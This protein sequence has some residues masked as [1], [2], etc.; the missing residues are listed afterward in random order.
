MH[1][2]R[3]CILF[4][5]IALLVV[6]SVHAELRSPIYCDTPHIPGISSNGERPFTVADSI[7][8]SHIVNYTASD[9]AMSISTPMES[10]DLR[11][12]LLVTERGVVSTNKTESTIWAFDRKQAVDYASN[13]SS[14]HPK[15][16][17]VATL[18]ATANTPVISE[19][20]WLPDSKRIAFLGKND[21]PYQQLFIASIDT[22]ELMAITK[23]SVYVSAYDISG[24][25]VAYSSLLTAPGVATP[26]ADVVDVTG[27]T[28][29]SFLYPGQPSI[30]NLEW[31][32][33]GEFAEELHVER[34]GQELPV[35]FA[36]K[37]KPLRLFPPTWSLAPPLSLSPDGKFLI[38]VSPANEIPEVWSLYKP[39]AG[40]KSRR[41][42][43]DAN[44]HTGDRDPYQ[45]LQFVLV[46]LSSG[47][48][49]PLVDAPDG[50]SLGYVAPV[51]AFW[52]ADS[53]RAILCNTFLPIGPLVSRGHITPVLETPTIA[54]VEV[55]TGA[56][57]HIVYLTSASNHV[58]DEYGIGNISWSGSQNELSV[59]YEGK[60]NVPSPETFTLRSE[61][62]IKLAPTSTRVEGKSDD[63]QLSVEEG[64][65]R[66]PVLAAHRGDD[67]KHTI[68][69]DPNP[70]LADIQMGKVCIYHW[71]DK[72]G[73]KWSGILALPPDFDPKKRYPLVIQTHGYDLNKY[74]SD[75]TYTTGNAG[76]ALAAIGVI[77]LQMGAPTIESFTPNEGPFELG[78][79]EG[80]IAQLAADGMIDSR[81]VGIS[82]FSRTSFH[83]LYALTHKPDLFAAAMDS[84]GTNMGYL[85]YLMSIDEKSSLQEIAEGTNGGIPFGPALRNWLLNAP[86]FNL[87]RMRTPLLI[88]A[89]E[90]GYVLKQWETYAGL[91]RLRKPVAMLWM[92]RD[93]GMHVLRRP[94]QVFASEQ[95][96]VDWFDFW[97]NG[98][99]DP[100][101][102][103]LEQYSRWR[104]LRTLP[105]GNPCTTSNAS[106]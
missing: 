72:R 39:A 31:N 82:G 2:L 11:F 40:M 105:G 28:L 19:V 10:P 36:M 51:E 21:S 90:P 42:N 9:Q 79:F 62:W 86:G 22:S 46:E 52:L 4:C 15:P 87:C 68:I 65:D 25:T 12:F 6:L 98:H 55:S 5:I 104:E 97:L 13:K 49:S 37:G 66:S 61:R 106:N 34:H 103:K 58:G 101:P 41:I 60:G 56:V 1:C 35:S 23:S 92:R 71:R 80:A 78:G 20:R 48:V 89:F 47:K 100:E 93:D 73:H 45:P 38:T 32:N 8:I 54:D 29:S 85:Q 57:R 59:T 50:R 14:E 91:R 64:V 67:A 44:R 74:F 94:D 26:D 76:R 102:S 16:K 88:S 77:V 63:L 33:V 96:A 75:G 70:Q 95:S 18:S 81:R 27:R 7:E 84:N 17:A 24:D 99:E 3:R 53:K 43:A 83:V 30:E 69:W